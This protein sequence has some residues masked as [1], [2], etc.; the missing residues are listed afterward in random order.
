MG[1]RR[2]RARNFLEWP[3]MRARVVAAAHSFRRSAA[4]R[5]AP[6]SP[7]GRS[8]PSRRCACSSPWTSRSCCW[9]S[10]RGRSSSASRRR[11][12]RAWRWW[13]RG[14]GAVLEL[15]GR[16]KFRNGLV[17]RTAL[18]RPWRP[19]PRARAA[20]PPPPRSP[21]PSP[22]SSLAAAAPPL[23][24]RRLRRPAARAAFLRRHANA[25]PPASI[26]AP[27][28]PP[29]PPRCRRGSRARPD[30]RRRPPPHRPR[31]AEL[32]TAT[33]SSST[34]RMRR[35]FTASTCGR[36]GSPTC[37]TRCGCWA[38][39]ARRGSSS[40]TARRAP[41]YPWPTV[42]TPAAPP[43]AI[44]ASTGTLSWPAPSSSGRSSATTSTC[45]G[46]GAPLPW[47]ATRSASASRR[48]SL[49][50]ARSR[51]P[52]PPTSASAAT[53]TRPGGTFRPS[54]ARATRRSRRGRACSSRMAERRAGWRRRRRP[55]ASRLARRAW[56]C[57]RIGARRE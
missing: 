22:T 31:R 43:A 27:I 6:S 36:A 39:A 41:R 35:T 47:P 55:T 16:A 11:G 12:A 4:P 14:R 20:A 9:R 3:T 10:G 7:G 38:T 17:T 26:S 50:A 34:C 13:R 19:T 37:P 15:D 2:A 32:R 33:L 1:G 5:A 54:T 8:R 56:C 45:I 46:G 23:R 24:D 48:C 53:R 40:S 28:P 29:P 42:A 25:T 49:P 21:T 52:S 30:L 18:G 57:A 51:P 44:G